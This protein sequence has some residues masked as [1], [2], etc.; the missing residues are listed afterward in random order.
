MKT[1][2]SRECYFQFIKGLLTLLF[3]SSSFVPRR[4]MNDTICINVKS[5]FNLRNTTWC[6]WYTYQSELPKQFVIR[7]HFT[8]TLVHFDFNLCLAIRSSWKNLK[9]HFKLWSIQ[10]LQKSTIPCFQALIILQKNQLF[11]ILNRLLLNKFL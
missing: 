5:H 3:F 11:T 10:T 7:S 6:R 8:F 9:R 1:P 4:H 2:N